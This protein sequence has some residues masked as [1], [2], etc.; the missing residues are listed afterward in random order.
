MKFNLTKGLSFRALRNRRRERNWAG[1]GSIPKPFYH[2]EDIRA[3]H[4]FF[5]EAKKRPGMYP[6][7]VDSLHGECFV[8]GHSVDFHIEQPPQG[9]EVNWRET[10]SCPG[11]GLINRWRS[12]IHLFEA[13][14][15]PT[16]RDRIYLTETLTPVY[17]ELSKRYP[18]LTGSEFLPEGKPGELLRIQGKKV[19]NEDVTAL[20]FDDRSFD[21]VL[22]FDVLEHVPDYRGALREFARVLAPGGQLLLSVPFSFQPETRVRAVLEDDGEIRHIEEPCYHGD[23]LSDEGVL[24]FYDFGLELLDEMKAAGFDEAFILCFQ[25][26]RWAYL[27]ENVAFI[28]RKLTHPPVA[29]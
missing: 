6:D 25:S 3:L 4:V 18:K 17:A 11:C 10:L 7:G 5:S 20:S 28:A 21:S 9:G 23:P 1:P 24:S 14:C 8:C 2:P 27:Q 16:R 29:D 12:C 22:C 26:I 13:L 19:R 15:Q